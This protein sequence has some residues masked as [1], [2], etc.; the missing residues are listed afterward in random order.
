MSF[1]PHTGVTE[2][3][4]RSQGKYRHPDECQDLKKMLKQ[5]QHDNVEIKKLCA[6]CVLCG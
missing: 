1:L 5:V 3:T 2:L 4:Q 6:L